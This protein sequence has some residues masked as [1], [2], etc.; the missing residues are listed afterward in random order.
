MKR[1]LIVLVGVVAALVIIVGTAVA[2]TLFNNR[3]SGSEGA[4]QQSSYASTPGHAPHG[5]ASMPGWGWMHGGTLRNEADYLT[6]MVAH[7]QEAVT[8]ATQLQRS[9]RPQMRAFGAAIVKTQSAQ[10]E[11]MNRWL[12]QWYPQRSPDR[13]YE[14][15]MRD[16]THL[17]GNQ[18]DR[19][20]LQD[21]IG[22]H[23]AAVMMSQQLLVR[24][25]AE[26]P[27]V[28]RLALTIRNDQHAEIF[29]MMRWLRTWYHQP[30]PGHWRSGHLYRGWDNTTPDGPS[31]QMGP[32]MMGQ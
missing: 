24:G 30:W 7:H 27:E 11:Q 6:T 4:G 23:M 3:T 13:G 29:Q 2:T 10:I 9:D 5:S 18:L 12:R 31:G 25:L 28:N 1:W 26:H 32:G 21:M 8:A 19:T 17:S 15:M 20:F 14:P 16:L 22:H